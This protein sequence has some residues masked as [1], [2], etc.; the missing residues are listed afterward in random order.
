MFRLQTVSDSCT[1]VSFEPDHVG[2]R[3][4]VKIIELSAGCAASFLLPVLGAHPRFESKHDLLFIE[5]NI[6]SESIFGLHGVFILNL[7]SK[8]W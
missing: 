3:T 1:F 2:S 8:F 7:F 6:Y 5:V 4:Q